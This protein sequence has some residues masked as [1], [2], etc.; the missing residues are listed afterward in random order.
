MG[1]WHGVL[2]VSMF[3]QYYIDEMSKLLHMTV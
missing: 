3:I 2:T 1:L